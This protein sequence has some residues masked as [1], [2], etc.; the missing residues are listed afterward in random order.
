M[1]K[2]EWE[3]MER[4]VGRV[5]GLTVSACACM[6]MWERELKATNRSVAW[7]SGAVV[8]QIEGYCHIRSSSTQVYVLRGPARSTRHPRD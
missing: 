4:S 6:H 8:G 7:S 5:G 2:Q 1:G 3:L